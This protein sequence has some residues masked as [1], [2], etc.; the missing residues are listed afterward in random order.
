[1][2]FNVLLED[3]IK[4]LN[5]KR[6]KIQEAMSLMEDFPKQLSHKILVKLL[7]FKTFSKNLKKE[8]LA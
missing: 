6:Q 1:M 3:K 7:I 2:N 4:G 8:F 5:I